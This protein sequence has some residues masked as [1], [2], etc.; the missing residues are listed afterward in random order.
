MRTQLLEE[1]FPGDFEILCT[2]IIVSI[3]MIVVGIF[4]IGVK[5]YQ[6]IKSLLFN[7]WK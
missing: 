3:G 6:T 2:L 4:E 1:E 5:G 7:T